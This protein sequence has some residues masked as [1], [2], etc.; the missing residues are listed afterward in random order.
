MRRRHTPFTLAQARRNAHPGKRTQAAARAIAREPEMVLPTQAPDD[1]PLQ[2]LRSQ[3]W[4]SVPPKVRVTEDRVR[5]IRGW[6]S[7]VST[8]DAGATR[9][10]MVR[11]DNHHRQHGGAK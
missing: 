7:I 1:R 11:A 4:I 9:A 6:E 10:P 5:K 3:S 2:P 8:F